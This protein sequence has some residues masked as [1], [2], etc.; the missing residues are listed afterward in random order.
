MGDEDIPHPSQTLLIVDSGYSIISW[1]HS[2]DVPPITLDKRN[3]E[4]TAYVPGLKINKDKN[5]K[6]GQ[7]HDAINGRHLNKKVNI[8]FTDG[9]VARKKAD[10]LCVEKEGDNYRN[11][12]PLWMPE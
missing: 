7:I 5:L 3:I 9:H 4:D 10:D 1:W 2:T 6:S 12:S 11:R 8:G